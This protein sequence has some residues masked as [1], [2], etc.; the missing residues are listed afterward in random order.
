MEF[1]FRTPKI[2]KKFSKVVK[3]SKIFVFQVRDFQ[4]SEYVAC[5]FQNS[6]HLKKFELSTPFW[7]WGSPKVSKF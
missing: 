3:I 2:F 6:Y 5:V 4:S 7:G 1:W